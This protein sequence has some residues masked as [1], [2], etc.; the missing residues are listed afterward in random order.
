MRGRTAS[1]ASRARGA[2]RSSGAACVPGAATPVEPAR[3]GACPCGELGSF[4][5]ARS[6]VVFAE[7][8]RSLTLAVKRRARSETVRAVGG[9]LASLARREGLAPAGVVVTHVP[10][11]RAAA[12]RGFDHAGLIA[13]ATAAALAVPARRL[14]VRAREGPRQADV[15]L[16]QRRANVAGR[17]AAKPVDAPVLLVDDV[18]TTGA[19]AEACACALSAAGA[20][21]VD[22]RDVGE[23]AS[24][25]S[26]TPAGACESRS[27]TFEVNLILSGRGVE[28]DDSLRKYATE[29][30]TRVERFFDRII[31]MEV[32]LRHERNP[33][34]KD[35]DRVEVTVK[36]PRQTLRVHGEGLDHFAAIDVAADRLEAQIKKVKERLK[37][38]HNHH[39]NNHRAP[40]AHRRRRRRGRSGDRP[41]VG[42]PWTSRS[43][44]RRRASS[45]RTGG[46][47]SSCSSTPRRCGLRSCTAGPAATYGLVQA[48][49]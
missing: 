44:R 48:E 39:G 36:T 10:A 40:A 49:T 2:S 42:R 29:K 7:P 27:Y 25:P 43:P 8:A 6:L 5:R 17:F 9:L 11:G 16:E 46:C 1:C 32:E 3:A 24:P 26:L 14:L 12:K 41:C 20:R 47:S 22:V 19:T 35:P 15:S 31:K 23:D 4:R 28:L 45:W 38:H 37:D 21:S 30:L 13:R 18:F 33:R 34:V